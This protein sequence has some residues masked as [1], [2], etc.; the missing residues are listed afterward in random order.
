MNIS[1]RG[2]EIQESP[3]R[4]LKP[5][6]E[7]NGITYRVLLDRKG[8]VS[9]TYGIVG[10]PSLVIVDRDGTVRFS[11]TGLPEKAR[12]IIEELVGQGPEGLHE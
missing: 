1:K 2:L 3:I 10:L 9:S 8:T 7:K 11:G 6:A 4:K 12:K 5:F